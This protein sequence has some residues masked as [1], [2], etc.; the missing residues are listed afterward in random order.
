MATLSARSLT[1]ALTQARNIGLVE[2]PF[3]VGDTSIVVRNLRPDQYD[4]IF[5]ECQGLNDVEYLNAWQ[6]GHICRSI[7]EINGIDLRDTQYVEEEEPDPK[8]PGQM[9]VV[10]HEL[11]AWLRREVVSTWSRETIYICYRKVADAVE[12]AEKQAQ[13]GVS[14]RVSDESPEDKAR[15]LLGELKDIQDSVPEKILTNVLKDHG[16]VR[17]S[18][19][20]DI[21]AVESKLAQVTPTAVPSPEPPKPEPAQAEPSKP[22]PMPSSPQEAAPSPG[23]ATVRREAGP[24]TPERMAQLL[25]ARTPMNQ[26]PQVVPQEPQ[27]EQPAIVATPP[28]R[29]PPNAVPQAALS[30]RT[31][32]LASLE[33]AIG[34]TQGVGESIATAFNPNAQ[35]ASVPEIRGGSPKMDP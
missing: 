20:E 18:A 24:P 23:E 6:I 28:V 31:M 17:L 11:H 29:I 1:Q 2:E 14:F 9:K 32:E 8:K 21:E 4:S 7:C 34:D 10:K 25:R 12:A 35:Q 13:D 16:L 27:V 26:Q 22:V 3:V 15:R 33:N 19:Q 5:K 30:G